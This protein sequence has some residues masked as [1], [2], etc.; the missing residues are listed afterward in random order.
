MSE[1]IVWWVRKYARVLAKVWAAFS[2]EPTGLSD[3][4]TLHVLSQHLLQH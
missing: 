4:S 3:M 2:A 1:Q